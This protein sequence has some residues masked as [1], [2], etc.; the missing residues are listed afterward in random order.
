MVKLFL[1]IATIGEYQIISDELIYSVKNSGLLDKCDQF[2]VCIVGDSKLD[3]PIKSEKIFIKNVGNI[4]DY[5]FPTL[6]FIENDIDDGDII[7]YFNGL[8]VTDNSIYKKSW[9]KYLTYFN[10]YRFEECIKSLNDGFDCCGVDWRTNPVPHFSGNF[11]WAKCSYLKK[12][13][14][15]KTL[16]KHNSIKILT[17]RHNAEMYIGMN[18]NVKVR[19]LHQSNISQY[20]RHLYTYNYDLYVNIINEN[21]IIREI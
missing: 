16:N 2:N 8:G 7:F 13:P 12:L 5:E 1:H 11:W 19:I 21:N 15:I 6:E 17:L 20:E 18:D 14:E 4:K 3:I 9:R 10:I